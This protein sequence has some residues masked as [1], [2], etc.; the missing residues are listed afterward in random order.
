M[1][2]FFSTPAAKKTLETAIR[3]TQEQIDKISENPK[4]SAILQKMK[5]DAQQI[6]SKPTKKKLS[7]DD[8]RKLLD[9]EEE[10]A[11]FSIY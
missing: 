4:F 8:I 5:A 9:K 11:K 1:K 3:T 2:K 6:S 7:G 10:N